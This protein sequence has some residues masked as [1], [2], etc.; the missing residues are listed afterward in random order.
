VFVEEL[1]RKC[2]AMIASEDSSP[3]DLESVLRGALRD[4]PS[5]TQKAAEKIARVKTISEA[6]KRSERLE[7]Q[8]KASA[9]RRAPRRPTALRPSPA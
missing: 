5:L 4:N 1:K 3:P 6:I 9:R 8:R 2:A 7:S